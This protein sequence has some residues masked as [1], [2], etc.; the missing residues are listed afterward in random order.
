MMD[1]FCKHEIYKILLDY[2]GDAS[3][4]ENCFS[5]IL[6]VLESKRKNDQKGIDN[7]YIANDYFEALFYDMH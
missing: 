2:I 4:A 7:K 3:S 1:L 5:E 6:A